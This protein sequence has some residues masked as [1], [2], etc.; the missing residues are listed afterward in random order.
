MKNFLKK[1]GVAI[2]VVA[3]VISLAVAIGTR[4]GGTAQNPDYY[5]Q[6]IVDDAN[7]LSAS[8]EQ[9]LAAYNEDFNE[10]YGSIIA[11]YTVKSLGGEDIADV[12][13][14]K[15]VDAELGEWDFVLL[16]DAGTKDWYVVPGAEAEY[17]VDNELENIFITHMRADVFSGKADT[18][19]TAIF[20]DMGDWYEDNSATFNGGTLGVI[21]TI[22]IYALML[23]FIVRFLVAPII[24]YPVYHA[25]RPLWGWGFW[26]PFHFHHHHH[27]RHHNPPPP[28]GGFGGHNGGFGSGGNRGGFGGSSRGGGFGGGRGGGFGGGSR[29]GGFGRR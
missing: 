17:Y 4:K 23:F 27:H 11:V 25:W 14:N 12:A 18:R 13:Y 3:I 20:D 5:L 15:G 8:T 9:K 19:L 29:G 21:I 22:V 24:T 28:G 26:G 2:A 1:Y 10:E 6:W 16:L 7:L